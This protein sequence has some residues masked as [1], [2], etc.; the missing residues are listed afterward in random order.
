MTEYVQTQIVTRAEEIDLVKGDRVHCLEVLIG[1]DI[2]RRHVI[3]PLGLKIGRTAPADVVLADADVSRSH[4][5]VILK[6]DEVHVSDLNSTNGTYIDGVK[7]SGVQILPVGSLLQ[8]G[9]RAMK[10]EWRTRAEVLH[11]DDVD[12]D[13]QRA[14][15]YVKA[16]LPAP[17]REGPI[18]ADWFYKPSAKLGGDAFGYGRLSD[19]LY[20]CYLV[21]VAGHGAGSAMHA[22]AIMNQLRQKSLPNTDMAQPELVLSTLN[23]LF[24]MDD[25]DGLYFTIWYG[26]YDARE[27]RLDYA[28]GGHHPAYLLPP[29]RSSAMPLRTRNVV[30]G[31][32]PA[33]NFTQASVNVPPGSSLFVFSDGCYEIIDSQGNQW[34]VEDFVSLILRPEIPAI[35][36]PQRLYDAVCREAR[37]QALEDDFSLFVVNFD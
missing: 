26:V 27:R 17:V 1:G 9:N 16:L 3:G 35:P 2:E 30:I 33:M 6:D 34:A 7:I 32:M 24:Q 10:H 20:V 18:R 15:S 21:D 25:H 22:V 4:C 31:G 23:E 37:P 14:A 29:E 12:R 8:T 36:E 13:L 19:D 11:S 5:M 28:S